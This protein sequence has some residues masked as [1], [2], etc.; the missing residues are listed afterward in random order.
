MKRILKQIIIFTMLIA[1]IGCKRNTTDTIEKTTET[2][3]EKTKETP[4]DSTTKSTNQTIGTTMEQPSD[5]TSCKTSEPTIIPTNEPSI[6]PTNEP[7]IAQTIE[8]SIAQTV[9]EVV[10]P[11]IEATTMYVTKRVNFRVAPSAEAD[12]IN[13]VEAR[14]A[15]H[16]IGRNAQWS[17]VLYDG[18]EG[19]MASEFLSE[20]EPSLSGKLIVIDAGHQGKGNPE[21]E[22][23]GPGASEMKAK[24]SSGTTGVASGLAEYQLT[25]MVSLKL[26]QELLRRGYQVIMTRTT[27]DINMSNSERAKIANEANADAFIRVHANGSTNPSANGAL[28]ICQTPANPYNGSLAATSKRLSENVLNAFCEATGCKRE[29]IWET[30]TMSGI[31]WCTV[32]VTIIEMGYMTN[33]AEDLAMANEEYQWKMVQGMAN[34]MDAFFNQ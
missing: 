20:Q 13:V 26:E 5:T 17:R 32:P 23:V 25:L 1:L 12:I 24:V 2:S 7:S 34:G 22:P 10:I 31:N 21:K 16:V 11:A 3:L 28:T 19:Y 8:P 6:A 27:H 29:Y 4:S 33:Q 15:I 30:D 18:Q 9:E 14:A